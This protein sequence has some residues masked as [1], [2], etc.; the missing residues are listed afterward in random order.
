VYSFFK[1]LGFS[2]QQHED[3]VESLLPTDNFLKAYKT[4][5][6]NTKIGCSFSPEYLEEITKNPTPEVGLKALQFIINDLYM[7]HIRLGIR[8]NKVEEERGKI[9]F[10]YYKP[11][12][13]YCLSQNV[14]ICLNIGP[15]KTF[16]WPEQYVPE[17]ALKS[18]QKI[19][20]KK[21]VLDEKS[22]IAVHSLLYA[23]RLL[24]YLA[25]AY[26]TKELARITLVQ[27]EN[28][29]FYPFGVYSWRLSQSYMTRLIVLV[30]TYLPHAGIM[31]N[32]AETRNL[33]A[34]IR[35]F[36]SLRTIGYQNT[37]VSGFN[38]Y[39]AVPLMQ[40]LPFFMRLDSIS[41]TQLAGRNLCR[42]NIECAKDFGYSIEV[43]EAQFEPWP[44]M[45]SPGSSAQE[46]RYL[47]IRCISYILNTQKYA[48]IR[49]WGIERLFYSFYTKSA[50]DEHKEIVEIIKQI[51]IR[52]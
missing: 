23:E 25:K 52:A 21:A 49:L 16:R 50:T 2:L 44:P 26:S 28:E 7:R 51:N 36:Q 13:D 20:K 27:P 8:W 39:Y 29:S 37:L 45:M 18:L 46:F 22:E 11:Y 42:K 3:W 35:L 17:W 19:P 33:N 1:K 10:S 41:R 30:K 48:V 15:I 32:S 40:K 9:D 34:I 24:S 31:L 12:F 43:S 5:L 4:R 38:Y 47:L 6:K 14:S